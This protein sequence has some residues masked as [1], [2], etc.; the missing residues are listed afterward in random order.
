MSDD[1]LLFPALTFNT[2]HNLNHQA[3]KFFSS[4]YSLHEAGCVAQTGSPSGLMLSVMLHTSLKYCK[5]NNTTETIRTTGTKLANMK[6]H[7]PKGS[8]FKVELTE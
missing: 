1:R 8:V 7:Q 6:M 3:G 4:H 2:S 5:A